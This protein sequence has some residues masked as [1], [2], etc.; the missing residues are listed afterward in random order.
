MEKKMMK[1]VF[2]FPSGDI[3]LVYKRSSVSMTAA[4]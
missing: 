4:S 3:K 1:S 2:G